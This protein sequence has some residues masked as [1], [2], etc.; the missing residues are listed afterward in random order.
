MRKCELLGQGSAKPLSIASAVSFCFAVGHASL[1]PGAGP[2]K[3]QVGNESSQGSEVRRR[4]H[5]GLLRR[6]GSALAEGG[7]WQA[8]AAPE[9]AIGPRPSSA[10]NAGLTRRRCRARAPVARDGV[11]VLRRGEASGQQRST[12]LGY[13]DD[14]VGDVPGSAHMLAA[15]ARPGERRALPISALASLTPMTSTICTVQYGVLYCRVERRAWLVERGEGR[16]WGNTLVP[17]RSSWR[18]WRRSA[19]ARAR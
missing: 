18:S 19:Q 7:R 12:R 4:R 13:R 9:R 10:H 17:C 6:N 2:S 8:L 15:P 3:F 16:G 11:T 14:M 1:E 5:E